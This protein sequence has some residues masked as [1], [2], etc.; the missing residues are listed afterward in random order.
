MVYETACTLV[1]FQFLHKP[2]KIDDL[3]VIEMLLVIYDNMVLRLDHYVPSFEAK[4]DIT[5]R[6]RQAGERR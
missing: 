6:I 3:S 4:T 2:R 1:R 5:Q